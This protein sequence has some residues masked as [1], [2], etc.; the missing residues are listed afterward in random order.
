MIEFSDARPLD[1]F[2]QNTAQHLRR[3]K[4]TGRPVVLTVDGHEE[5]VVQDAES[6]RRLLEELEQSQTVAGI[7]RG[8]RSMRRGA[9]RPMRESLEQLARKHGVPLRRAR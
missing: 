1:D 5:V 2:Q 9:G 3:L 8:L 6:Y 4:K 7:K